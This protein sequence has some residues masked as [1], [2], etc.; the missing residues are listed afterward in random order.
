MNVSIERNW[1]AASTA[2][3][4]VADLFIKVVADGLQVLIPVWSTESI[5]AILLEMEQAFL[6]DP[7]TLSHIDS[8]RVNSCEGEQVVSEELFLHLG[9]SIEHLN[10]AL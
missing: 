7:V 1:L 2:S 10:C 8:A 4:I 5:D 6:V 3:S 9:Q